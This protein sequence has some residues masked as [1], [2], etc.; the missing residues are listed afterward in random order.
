MQKLR[1][2]SIVKNFTCQSISA[3]YILLFLA[4]AIGQLI[5]ELKIRSFDRYLW[6]STYYLLNLGSCAALLFLAGFLLGAVVVIQD[7]ENH[8]LLALY[9]PNMRA[10]YLAQTF[11]CCNIWAGVVWAIYALLAVVLWA[12]NVEP[13]HPMFL[14]NLMWQGV[15]Y[16]LLTAMA[17][18]AAGICS[19]LYVSRGGILAMLIVITLLSSNMGSIFVTFA[20]STAT[21]P[22]L[23]KR[24]FAVG[25]PYGSVFGPAQLL[26]DSLSGIAFSSYRVI[27]MLLWVFGCLFVACLWAAPRQALRRWG[28][29]ALGMAT[30]L[31][32]LGFVFNSGN[33]LYPTTDN[34]VLTSPQEAREDHYRYSDYHLMDMST[35]E[36]LNTANF[37]VTDYQLNF[38]LA[39]W[40]YATV[41]ATVD[42][43]LDE[44]TFTLYSNYKVHW[45]K[46]SSGNK[47]PF[48]RDKDY[49]VLQNTTGSTSFTF[50][51]SGS[52]SQYYT[53]ESGCNLPGYAYYYPR[54]GKW[55]ILEWNSSNMCYQHHWESTANYTMTCHSLLP[56]YTNLA[57]QPDGTYAGRTNGVTVTTGLALT[58]GERGTYTYYDDVQINTVKI[59]GINRTMQEWKDEYGL[60]YQPLNEDLPLFIVNNEVNVPYL[61]EA[62][63]DHYVY[64]NTMYTSRDI[65]SQLVVDQLHYTQDK[66]FV[67]QLL[68]ELLRKSKED[69]ST[70]SDLN[71]NFSNEK[72]KL[73]NCVGYSSLSEGEIVRLLADYL[74]DD[75]KNTAQDF[76][77]LCNTLLPTDEFLAI[78]A[79]ELEDFGL[80]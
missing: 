66:A 30:C 43:P 59:S 14:F 70:F 19:G 5:S 3:F 40:L 15:L 53:Q 56:V 64:S 38:T 27:H 72:E 12:T 78:A 26:F 33:Q 29:I 50:C 31:C 1:F 2:K 54:A 10:K 73:Y 35:E 18:S 79:E 61:F 16:L 62:F 36:G 68:T 8:P 17:G 49:I 74:A 69:F 6:A 51:Y 7:K 48:T 47:L 63:D 24:L 46:D 28:T 60:D 34:Q 25:A 71:T 32:A 22:L 45:V 80:D 21:V 39:D 65:A 77:D 57:K 20:E 9:A 37:A 41:T 11:W 67:A 42:T 13:M 55:S 52:E 58:S 44:Y 76:F 4:F 75:S 23:I